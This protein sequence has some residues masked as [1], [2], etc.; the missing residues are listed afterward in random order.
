MKRILAIPVLL[1]ALAAMAACNKPSADGGV[2]S[3]N[4]SGA[5]TGTPRGS[6]DPNAMVNFAKCMREHGQDIPDPDPDSGQVQLGPSGGPAQ[7]PWEAAMQACQHFLPAGA[8]PDAVADPR[9]LE[10][11]RAYAVCMR[12]HGI[13]ISDPQPNGNMTIGGRVGQLT[14]PQRNAD[15]AYQGA[16]RACKDKLPK[17]GSTKDPKK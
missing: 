4:G 6:E 1:L 17:P 13:E 3:A 15:P 11:L 2:P 14:K 16:D 12:D 10:Q 8:G 5:P 7:G 9:E